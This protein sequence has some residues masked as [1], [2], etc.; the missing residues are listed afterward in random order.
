[1]GTQIRTTLDPNF[2]EE[3][4]QSPLAPDDI[5]RA[6][7]MF[8]EE[9]VFT[10]Q[11]LGRL[12]EKEFEG[13]MNEQ[14]PR[15]QRG[16]KVILKDLW[17]S[18][19]KWAEQKLKEEEL[20]QK[21][22]IREEEKLKRLKE[23]EEMK[24]Q[25]ADMK[26]RMQEEARQQKQL[27][28]ERLR[29][30]ERLAR[31]KA[32]VEEKLA[33]QAAKE[34]AKEEERL[35]KEE[36]KNRK[37][38][39]R[40]SSVKG[41]GRNASVASSGGGRRQSF[42]S[43]FLIV[44]DGDVASSG[45]DSGPTAKIEEVVGC[46]EPS[47]EGWKGYW[48]KARRKF[49]GM[50]WEKW[51]SRRF[52]SARK[53]GGE[54]SQTAIE[55]ANDL[56]LAHERYSGAGKSAESRERYGGR[57]KPRCVLVDLDERERPPVQLIMSC[58]SKAVSGRHPF[59][60]DAAID[61]EMDS[62]AEWAELAEGEDLGEDDDVSEDE[63]TASDAD[64]CVVSD[65]KLSADEMS[66][67]EECAAAERELI[68]KK[69]KKRRS[70]D[71]LATVCIS[72]G[73][74][75]GLEWPPPGGASAVLTSL[76]ETVISDFTVDTLDQSLLDAPGEDDPKPTAQSAASSQRGPQQGGGVSGEGP[77]RSPSGSD[78][79]RPSDSDAN[80]GAKSHQQRK[81]VWTDVKLRRKLAKF[82]HASAMSL[83]KLKQGFEEQHPQCA[84]CGTAAQIK[85]VA[86]YER[87]G[88][89]SCMAWWITEE[90]IKELKLQPKTMENLAEKRSWS[91][92]RNGP[93]TRKRR[94]KPE[95]PPPPTNRETANSRSGE[96][97][98]ESAGA[99]GS[100]SDGD[101]CGGVSDGNK[102][103][104]KRMRRITDY[105]P[106]QPP[107]VVVKET[108]EEAVPNCPVQDN[109]ATATTTPPVEGPQLSTVEAE[110]L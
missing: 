21:E 16:I 97:D 73:E 110:P 58:E 55:E 36:E 107:P 24:L 34:K 33:R 87:R 8:V 93:G 26:R 45:K 37:Q 15:L 101:G 40:A 19:H 2:Q 53:S 52:V 51:H 4:D 65:G 61:Y 80:G 67:D 48:R 32:R 70:A 92:T 20:A 14:Q 100:G 57:R 77:M 102:Q 63:E 74:I 30:Q 1:M 79:G 5:S 84:G 89:N 38:K 104:A 41:Q 7:A 12:P 71:V 17:L 83:G 23:K 106:V 6:V 29:E 72:L 108:S 9:R 90:A 42:I 56:R 103:D 99:G 85:R 76:R 44:A 49:N 66:E 69:T 105:F 91:L 10:L 109:I 35:R 86:K 50:E 82:V 43:S 88:A 31:E 22:R 28:R 25:A 13:L 95:Q 54:G 64:S 11:Q 75:D 47:L 62:D 98:D 96:G 59:G 27:E 3:L 81:K 39:E 94:L 68:K 18:W 60:K 46:A 78:T